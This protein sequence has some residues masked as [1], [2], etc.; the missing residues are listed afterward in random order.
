MYGH[1]STPASTA[2]SRSTAISMPERVRNETTKAPCVSTVTAPNASAPSERVISTC[3]AS[4]ASAAITIP[5]TFWDV[6]E[7]MLT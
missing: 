2:T 4:V 6:P 1:R 7:R 3:A 5:K